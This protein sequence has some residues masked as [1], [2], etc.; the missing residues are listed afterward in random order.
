MTDL[1]YAVVKASLHASD[2][3]VF[4]LKNEEIQA[5]ISR[6]PGSAKNVVNGV[7]INAN[8]LQV[9][10]SLGELGYR[11]VCSSGDSD[12]VWTLK[13]E[14]LVDPD[15]YPGKETQIA[16]QILEQAGQV[17]NLPQQYTEPARQ[18]SSLAGLPSIPEDMSSVQKKRKLETEEPGSSTS[19]QQLVMSD[20]DDALRRGSE[21]LSDDSQTKKKQ[22]KMG[23]SPEDFKEYL[24]DQDRIMLRNPQS[25]DNSATEGV[26]VILKTNECSPDNP[27]IRSSGTGP[28]LCSCFS[29]SSQQMLCMMHPNAQTMPNMQSMQSMSAAGSKGPKPIWHN[30]MLGE[31]SAVNDQIRRGV[32]VNQADPSGY[33]ALHYAAKNGNVAICQA[34]INGGA[35]INIQTQAGNATALHRAAGA[36]KTEVVKLLLNNGAQTLLRDID[37]RT[38]LHRAVEGGHEA[39]TTLLIEHCMEAMQ[40]R[41]NR[42]CTPIDLAKDE[43]LKALIKR[44][45]SSNIQP[46]TAP[47]PSGKNKKK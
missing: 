16:R 30:A 6:Y 8:P 43:S 9:I 32:N 12:I 13:R 35:Q 18:F 21:D 42:G 11:V 24:P 47:S 14:G 17:N 26:R 1:F 36:G 2:A 34:L 20:T 29:P 19:Q 25:F 3:S 23:A 33:T 38:A 46:A 31:A 44:I 45:I 28:C 10:N 41:D 22:Y 15:Y 5:L 37:G 40:V 39:A 7:L 27:L 4:G